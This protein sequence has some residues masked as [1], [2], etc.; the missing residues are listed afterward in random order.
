[1][2]IKNKVLHGDCLTV[3]VDIPNNSIDHI[4]CDLPFF[5]IV[6]EEWDNQWKTVIDYLE[7]IEKIIIEYKRILK[8][9]GNILLFTGRQYNH[10]ICN[11]LD[12]FFIEKRIIIWAR[13]RNFN[14]TRGKALASGYEPI[15]YYSNSKE[16]IFNN[17]KIKSNSTR[18]EYT[19]GIL[20]DGITLSDVWSD[21][22][23]LPH[24]SKEKLKHPTQKPKALIDRLIQVFTNED[25]LVLDNCAGTGTTAISCIDKNR[26][27]LLIESDLCYYNIIIDR[28]ENFKKI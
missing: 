26:N 28:I 2:D 22:P 17:I 7:W 6:S 18:K 12:K 1:M 23:A 15:C 27:Y 24:N 4:I 3:M 16:S 13:K 19:D 14:N 25:D 10:K 9:N 5:G 20:K 21:I 8:N 11:I